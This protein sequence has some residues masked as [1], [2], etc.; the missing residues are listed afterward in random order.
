MKDKYSLK[1]VPPEY[2]NGECTHLI[3]AL[4]PN[5]DGTCTLNGFRVQSGPNVHKSL[6]E[7]VR[8]ANKAAAE[9]GSWRDRLPML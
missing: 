3:E 5:E 2:R 1:E 6:E 9:E 4:T 8:L 7:L